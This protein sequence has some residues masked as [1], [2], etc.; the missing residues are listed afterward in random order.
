M[1]KRFISRM[2][3]F[4]SVSG[5]WCVLSF[6]VICKFIKIKISVSVHSHFLSKGFG[7]SHDSIPGSFQR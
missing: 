5:G 6:T 7:I 3:T 2:C 1:I 4:V